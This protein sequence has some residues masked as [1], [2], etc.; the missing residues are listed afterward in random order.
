MSSP[1]GCS[2]ARGRLPE[3]ARSGTGGHGREIL[4]IVTA[5]NSIT[6][7]WTFVG[8]WDDV[9]P[10]PSLLAQGAVTWLGPVSALAD[11]DVGSVVRI[12]DSTARAELDRLASGWG[13]EPA[14]LV[15][16]RASVGSV[17]FDVELGPGVGEEPRHPRPTPQT[18]RLATT[19]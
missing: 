17:G 8:F 14:T 19:V 11:V 9:R 5:I 16:P 6:P 2:E 12:G 18:S 10:D 13:R 7:T 3:L 15:H 4:D 1:E